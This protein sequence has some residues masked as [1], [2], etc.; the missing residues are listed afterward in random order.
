MPS[1][2]FCFYSGCERTNPDHAGVEKLWGP[3]PGGLFSYSHLLGRIGLSRGSVAKERR[4]TNQQT[5]TVE[6][7]RGEPATCAFCLTCLG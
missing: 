7:R 6:E 2:S 1:T 4:S 5:K 3:A